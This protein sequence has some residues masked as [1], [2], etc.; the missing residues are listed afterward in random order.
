[1]NV[2]RQ[3]RVGREGREKESGWGGVE[4][5]RNQRKGR[6]QRHMPWVTLLHT[7]GD[8][9]MLGG[10][11]SRARVRPPRRTEERRHFWPCEHT[12]P[13]TETWGGVHISTGYR[14]GPIRSGQFYLF[15]WGSGRC[16]ENP[17]CHKEKA[18]NQY[19]ILVKCSDHFFSFTVLGIEPRDLHMLSKYSTKLETLL[20]QPSK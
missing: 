1:M 8:P 13:T 17:A 20:L 11:V 6:G 5:R 3:V 16:L 18:Q 10:G 19:Y 15:F 4:R 12:Y 9:G 2:S 14:V 7:H